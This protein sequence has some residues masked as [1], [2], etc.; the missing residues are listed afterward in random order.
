MIQPFL[1]VVSETMG[2]QKA[3]PHIKGL[4]HL[5]NKALYSVQE[6]GL[7]SCAPGDQS[8]WTYYHH[9]RTRNSSQFTLKQHSYGAQVSATVPLTR[10]Q[11]WGRRRPSALPWA[12]GCESCSRAMNCRTLCSR[13]INDA[14][15][16]FGLC[17]MDK[18]GCGPCFRVI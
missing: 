7:V 2:G 14:Y 4:A 6:G 18:K 8:T 10:S 1:G 11:R 9:H 13:T 15:E 16:R 3:K 5:F 12:D 17:G